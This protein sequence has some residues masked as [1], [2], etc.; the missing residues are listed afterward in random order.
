MQLT[1]R[2]ENFLRLTKE[3]DIREVQKTLNLSDKQVINIISAIDR[4]GY[5][6]K[7]GFNFSG[8]YYLRKNREIDNPKTIN[9]MGDEDNSFRCIAIADTHFLSKF[10]NQN[11]LDQVYKYAS[12]KN[13]PYIIHL[14][15]FIHDVYNFPE[16]KLEKSLSQLI[17]D[18]PS[19]KNIT[20][21]YIQGNHDLSLKKR[22]GINLEKF[23][24]SSRLDLVPLGI[25]FGRLRINKDLI[26][27]C[28]TTN[29]V[30]MS[31]E[32]IV[33]LK[34]HLHMYSLSPYINKNKELGLMVQ[35]PSLCDM[36]MRKG[37]RL[38]KGF[39]E[40]DLDFSDDNNLTDATV[41][42]FAVKHKVL[43]LG[44][45]NHRVIKVK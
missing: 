40:M 4:K 35:V 20:T 21:F 19:D 24:S 23:I 37:S 32:S 15:D 27:I 9:I 12:Y 43:K 38:E 30:E 29:L 10:S 7:P 1:E 41:T 22:H 26:N 45:Y 14:G 44:E 31:D 33:T 8:K 2:Q 42:Q 39:V 18:Y 13:I 3:N 6:I 5:E 36:N 16:S 28:H 34:G 11:S 25:D 17:K